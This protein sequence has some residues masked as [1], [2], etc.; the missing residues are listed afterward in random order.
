MKRLLLGS[1]LVTV[2]IL[3]SGCG[4]VYVARSQAYRPAYCS[5]CHNWPTG[6]VLYTQCAH[7]DI[8]ITKHGYMYR[9]YKHSGNNEYVFVSYQSLGDKDSRITYDNNENNS[10]KE[11]PSNQKGIRA[12]H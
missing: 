10:G 3:S 1:L 4:L 5:D 8:R 11:M 7:Y 6:Q 9:P 2:A 12:R